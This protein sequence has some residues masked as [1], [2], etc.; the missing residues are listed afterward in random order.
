[1]RL[2]SY[3]RGGEEREIN[4]HIFI[5]RSGCQGGGARILWFILETCE[6]RQIIWPIVRIGL[7]LPLGTLI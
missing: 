5:L 6:A 2:C 1:M 3:V 7:F 4:Y